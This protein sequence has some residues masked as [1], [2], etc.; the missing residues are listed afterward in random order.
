MSYPNG[1]LLPHQSLTHKT[2][3]DN[4]STAPLSVAVDSRFASGNVVVESINLVE[5]DCASSTSTSTN[6]KKQLHF[7]LAIGAD[8]HRSVK[9]PN[10]ATYWFYFA[11]EVV[12]DCKANKNIPTDCFFRLRVRKNEID[13]WQGFKVC[14]SEDN[15]NWHRL[16]DS[17]T[18]VDKASST[19]CWRISIPSTSGSE[20]A[21]QNK[22]WFAYYPPYTSQ[23]HLTRW[24]GKVERENIFEQSCRDEKKMPVLTLKRPCATATSS[25][26]TIWI[27]ARQHPGES[28]ANWMLEGFVESC[29]SAWRKRASVTPAYSASEKT[30]V[31]T[32]EED[33]F[34]THYTLKVIPMANPRGVDA[35]FW[36]TTPEGVNMNADWNFLN[37]V[38]TGLITRLLSLDSGVIHLDFHGDESVG[39]NKHFTSRASFCGSP[40]ASCLIASTNI[41]TISS[42]PSFELGKMDVVDDKDSCGKGDNHNDGGLTPSTSS[43][44]TSACSTS[45]ASSL[46]SIENGETE[47]FTV[48]SKKSTTRKNSTA[49]A[50]RARLTNG[51]ECV[52]NHTSCTSMPPIKKTMS[53]RTLRKEPQNT[54]LSPKA[55]LNAMHVAEANDLLVLAGS[56]TPTFSTKMRKRKSCPQQESWQSR[57]KKR[58][59]GAARQLREHVYDDFYRRFVGALV[60]REGENENRWWDRERRGERTDYKSSGCF[61]G[62][63]RNAITIEGC[64]KHADRKDASLEDE[65]RRAGA[66]IFSALCKV[67]PQFG[68]SL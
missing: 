10:K 50:L 53:K 33:F 59:V 61:D 41:S 24:L 63:W 3:P 36:Y 20:L 32:Q 23:E 55:R 62:R 60:N 38:E 4:T 47:R 57:M 34:F 17:S 2:F 5:D 45:S 29:S 48:R 27:V 30:T 6:K 52:K 9:H 65:A 11:I 13:S 56:A 31:T 64:M 43:P 16:E 68:A 25:K 67:L 26:R 51:S 42:M 12:D 37:S 18:V 19:V 28:I 58:P 7:D 15:T 35:G 21:G 49:M 14:V 22:L 8:P 54:P 46:T 44:A 1:P 66:D 39:N 40:I